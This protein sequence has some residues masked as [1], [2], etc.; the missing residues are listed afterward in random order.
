MR[1]GKKIGLAL[2]G[3]A[4]RG[5]AHVGALSVLLEAG[6]TFDYVAGCSAGAILGAL[7]CGGLP[8]GEI[9][10]LANHLSWRRLASRSRS[11]RGLLTLDKLERLMVM[12]IGD[13]TFA[14]LPIP[15]VVVAMDTA[16]GQRVVLEEG[17]VAAAVR[18]SSSVPGF[19]EPVPIAGRL[20]GDGGIIDNVPVTAARELGADFVIGVD[21]FEASYTPRYGPLG[22]G[23]MAIETMVRNAGGGCQ[24][25]DH[26]I[27][28][29]LGGQ[30]FIRFSQQQRLIEMGEQAARENLADLLAALNKL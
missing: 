24:A 23:L 7:Y 13:L 4:A 21:I 16:N 3:G 6:I 30:T 29:R 27:A 19:I 11:G 14:D 2:G 25:A 10:N 8:L 15:F 17:P 28:P 18:A 1:S 22:A 9:R 12:M 5:M 20:L 26:L